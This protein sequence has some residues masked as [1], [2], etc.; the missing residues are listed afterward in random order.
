[1]MADKI[2]VKANSFLFDIPNYPSKFFHS[3]LQHSLMEINTGGRFYL[4]F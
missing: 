4:K 1:M 3:I 2:K